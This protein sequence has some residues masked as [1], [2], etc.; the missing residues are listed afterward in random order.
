E[1]LRALHG[2]PD[3]YMPSTLTESSLLSGTAR[4]SRAQGASG[5]LLRQI[6]PFGILI[7]KDFT[8]IIN[9]NRDARSAVLA[10]LREIHDGRWTRYLGVD[11]GT[12]LTWMGKLGF[13]AGCTTAI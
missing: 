11:G 6:G 12:D 5:G 1:I 8:S 3:I 7:F 2:L 9:M 10:A 13:I 4:D